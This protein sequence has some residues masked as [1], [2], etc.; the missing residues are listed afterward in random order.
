MKAVWT[1]IQE[2][3]RPSAALPHEKSAL[4]ELRMLFIFFY[5]FSYLPIN[6]AIDMLY[7]L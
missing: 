2:E 5:A 4:T 1:G 7:F 3:D 6:Y